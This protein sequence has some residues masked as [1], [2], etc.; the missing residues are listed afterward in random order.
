VESDVFP[1]ILADV[2]RVAGP[3]AAV[4]L[5]RA[6]GGGRAYIPRPENLHPGHWLS[7][8]LGQ[9]PA[10]AVAEVLGG[11]EVEVPLGPA[12]G[13]RARVWASIRRGLKQGL[14]VEQAARQAGVSA[15]T[16]RRHKN[17]RTPEK[18]AWGKLPGV[19]FP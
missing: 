2:A 14:S 4:R 18:N 10:R 19:D 16:V 11:G 9:E 1:G 5:A 6:K 17:G 13:N 15:R 7:A 3:L 12:A 8:L